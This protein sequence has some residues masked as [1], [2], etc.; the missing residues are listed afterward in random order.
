MSRYVIVGAGAIGGCLG[1]RIAQNTGNPPLLVARG[2]NGEA[3]RSEGLLLRDP[4]RTARVRVPVA[5][6]PDEAQLRTDDVLVFATKTH[7]LQAAL[8]EWVD[9]PVRDADGRCVGTAGELLPVL[10]ALNGVESERMALRLFRR[11]YGVCVWVPAVHLRPAEVLIS[12][13]PLSGVFIVGRYGIV[14]RYRRP[15]GSAQADTDLLESVRTDWQA[16]G[17]GIHVVDDV[18]AW[19]HR[20]LL[21]NLGNAVQ[22]L[23]G[24]EGGDELRTAASEATW[25]ARTEALAAY[26]AA[27]ITIPDDRA[28]AA[29]RGDSFT[30]RPIPGVEAATGGSSWQSLARGTGSIE[31]DY[32][33][34]EIVLLGRRFGVATPVNETLQQMARIAATEGKGPASVT[35]QELLAAIR[36]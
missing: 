2:A 1:G 36:D 10:T 3:I 12:I 26:D 30:L 33:N 20:K 9:Q 27:G 7:Q 15:A 21:A 6:G 34:G 35:P 14:G 31:T 13:A 4:D 25:A 23:L 16:A 18:M 22:A 28:E 11:V 19:K 32:L 29:W 24:S 5:A 8:M 17:F